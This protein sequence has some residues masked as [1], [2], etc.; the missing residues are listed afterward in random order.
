MNIFFLDKDP[1]IAASYLCTAH[2]NKMILESAQLLSTTCNVLINNQTDGLYKSTH[3][4]HPSSMWLRQ[5]LGNCIWLYNHAKEMNNIRIANGAISHKSFEIC[6]IAYKLL[7]DKLP[8]QYF[9]LTD[10]YLAITPELKLK[11][12]YVLDNNYLAK[13]E[14]AV[15]AYREYYC[16]KQFKK[17]EMKWYN[18]NVPNWYLDKFN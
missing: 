4:N 13:P 18:N 2:L 3:I 10:V 11:Y 1:V 16:N 14:N 12:G 8:L 7:T 6:N 17:G 9:Q 15:L 5:S